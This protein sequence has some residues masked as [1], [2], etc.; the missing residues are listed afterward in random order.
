M[1]HR[2]EETCRK[3]KHNCIKLLKLNGDE[4][5]RGAVAEG[6]LNKDFHSAVT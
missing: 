1:R 3:D 5:D 2:Q 6:N 4:G